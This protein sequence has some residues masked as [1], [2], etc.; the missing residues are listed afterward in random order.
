MIL[1]KMTVGEALKKTEGVGGEINL[2]LAEDGI[3]TREP[4]NR[5]P[6]EIFFTG[7]KVFLEGNPGLLFNYDITFEF[8]GGRV[9]MVGQWVRYDRKTLT[10]TYVCVPSMTNGTFKAGDLFDIGD[11]VFD[12]EVPYSEAKQAVIEGRVL[13][14]KLLAES[15]PASAEVA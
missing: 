7:F 10:G 1:E 3:A 2:R 12:V 11:K 14:E 13:L 5:K 4:G 15:E 9:V 6:G 8:P